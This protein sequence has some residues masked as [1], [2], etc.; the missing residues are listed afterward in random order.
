ME[1]ALT[2]RDGALKESG[3]DPVGDFTFGGSYDLKSGV[4]SAI[5]WYETHKATIGAMAKLTGASGDCGRSIDLANLG[6]CSE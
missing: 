3:S 5:E 1:L 4:V 2:F 6:H